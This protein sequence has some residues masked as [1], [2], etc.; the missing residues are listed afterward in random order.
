MDSKTTSQHPSLELGRLRIPGLTIP[1]IILGFPFVVQPRTRQRL[2][3]HLKH[4]L[5]LSHLL[6]YLHNIHGLFTKD[7]KEHTNILPFLEYLFS[8]L[9]RNSPGRDQFLALHIRS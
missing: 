9:R 4:F 3:A 7:K 5:A 2:F 6:L 1:L 8:S